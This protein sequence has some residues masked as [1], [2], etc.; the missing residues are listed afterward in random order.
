MGAA[1][2]LEPTIIAIAARCLRVDPERIDPSA[3]LARYGLDSLSAL[4]LA[5]AIGDVIGI[6]IGED[7]L[8]DSPS[9]RSLVQRAQIQPRAAH[10]LPQDD[11][12]VR[13]ARIRTDAELPTDIDPM[14]V[15]AACG[16]TVL[17]TGANGFLGA[18]LIGELL[19]AGT[20]TLFCPVRAASD[21]QARARVHAATARY[22]LESVLDDARVRIFAADV[23]QPAFGL[24]SARFAELARAVSVVVHAA[25][26]LNW[27]APYEALRASNVGATETMLRFAC[28]ATRKR[29]HFVSSAAACYS[30]HARG[31]VIEDDTVPVLEGIHLGYAQS[32]W[33]AERLVSA[34]HERGLETV[35]YRPALIGGHSASGAGNA[36]DLIA[37]L[38][39]GC[40]ALGHAPELDWMLDVCPVDYVARAL[41]RIVR[42]PYYEQRVVHLCNSRPA[43]WNEAVLWLDLHGY[44]VASE[45]FAVWIER[46][47]RETRAPTHPL[48]PLRLFL[49]RQP[50]GEGGRY[51]P[52][53]YANPHSPALRAERSRAW[54]ERLG[55]RC[56]RLDSRL[57][58]R[59]A[60]HW[61]RDG[62]LPRLAQHRVHLVPPSEEQWRCALQDALRKYFAEPGLALRAA[63][64]RDF[65]SEHS[66][67]GELASWRSQSG[68]GL[69]MCTLH[70]I[71]SGGRA[72]TLEMVL[73]PKPPAQ[74][75]CAL[76]AEVAA[77]CDSE[78][79]DAFADYGSAG[80]LAAAAERE[81]ALYAAASGPLREC[82]PLYFGRI[83]VRDVPV[84]LLERV[85]NAVL[86][87]SV[88]APQLW[89]AAY[90]QAALDG[91]A[92]IHAQWLGRERELT[93]LEVHAI[94]RGTDAAATE[95]WLAA[96]AAHAE[97]WLRQWLGAAAARAHARCALEWA[98]R[99]TIAASLPR[100]L[101]HSDFNP[102]NVALRSTA[103]GARLCAYDWELAAYDLP[104]RDLIELLCFVLTPQTA[105]Q[106][107]GHLEY[108]RLALER[109]S[110]RALDVAA[111][112]SGVRIALAEFGVRRLPMYFIAHRFRA[113]IFLERVTRTWHV[114]ATTLGTSA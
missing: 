87:D 64:A 72:S 76:T 38:I 50:A 19:A 24:P 107:R 52:Q 74:R 29:L 104:Q 39:G 101:V 12:E 92:R 25:A 89:R 2:S 16:P 32:K 103:L 6:E 37:R 61:V 17:L 86:I 10:A 36:E 4:E 22:A 53:L 47:R 15:S 30:T 34:A 109:A 20:P 13:W 26:D 68:I 85:R 45:P 28:T 59:Y 69:H 60:D 41:A 44:R 3:P 108:A 42:S 46:V 111:W 8:L 83:Q 106:A 96:L 90:V 48:H 66:L 63:S 95:R 33:A 94:G 82:M 99:L 70:V 100:T 97:P 9:I 114:L 88:A 62:V 51:L 73:K 27:S 77:R 93:T 14:G 80:E 7:L 11:L 58:A 31:C 71:R 98:L 35:T 56:P 75:L 91:A 21:D 23:G 43:H 40:V 81:L 57:L 18:H 84:L 1:E 112:H 113:Q 105:A 102:R 49:L 65:G 110:G 78:L 5:T 55:V 54:L 67:L 79:G